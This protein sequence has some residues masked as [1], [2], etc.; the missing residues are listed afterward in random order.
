MIEPEKHTEILKRKPF[1]EIEATNICNLSCSFC[2]RDKIKRPYGMMDMNTF[3]KVL[4]FLPDSSKVMFSGMGEPLMNK[5]LPEFIEMLEQKN[6]F[7]GITTNGMLLDEMKIREI[8]NSRID[9]LQVS[10]MSFH[11]SFEEKYMVG[12]DMDTIRK[13]LNS[14]VE[15]T[16]EY[17]KNGKKVPELQISIIHGDGI[18]QDKSLVEFANRNGISIFNKK[19]HSRGGYLYTT[20]QSTNVCGIFARVTY[21]DWQGNILSCCHDLEGKNIIGNVNEDSLK[22]IILKKEKVIKE[23]SWFKICDRCDDEYRDILFEHPEILD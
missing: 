17:Q 10:G 19:L 7:V 12:T 9:F 14:L 11:K 2:P 21:L 1:F 16:Q 3:L 13:N 20:K 6:C 4:S 5:L 8:Y 23:N 22:H 15:T 18:P